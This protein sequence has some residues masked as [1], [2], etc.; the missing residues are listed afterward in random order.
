MG[1]STGKKVM[2]NDGGDCVVWRWLVHKK[3][4]ELRSYVLLSL[5]SWFVAVSFHPYLGVGNPPGYRLG[6]SNGIGWRSLLICQLKN[7]VPQTHQIQITLMYV[8]G[9]RISQ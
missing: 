9:M 5:H 4:L 8:I 2:K 7:G 1:K 6:G 3:I